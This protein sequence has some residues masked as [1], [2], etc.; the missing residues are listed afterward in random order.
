MA[1]GQQVADRNYQAFM[2]WAA[3]KSDDDFKE[4]AYRGKLKRAE[5]AAECCIGKS[6]LAQNPSIKNALRELEVDLMSRGVL[7]PVI[8][9]TDE[10]PPVRDRQATQRSRDSQRLNALEQQNAALSAKVGALEAKL[11]ELN[12][13][14]EFLY[15]TGRMPR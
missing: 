14:D 11:S 6:A 15:E 13:L 12:A 4:Y 2:A 7:P 1:N 3:S 5:I 9:A 8:V 10:Q